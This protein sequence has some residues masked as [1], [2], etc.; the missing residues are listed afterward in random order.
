ML[1]DSD[2]RRNHDVTASSALVVDDT[3][4]LRLL[5]LITIVPSNG[6]TLS[7]GRAVGNGCHHDKL[8]A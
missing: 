4:A 2:S 7:C 8:S 6:G 5:S 3:L 1:T